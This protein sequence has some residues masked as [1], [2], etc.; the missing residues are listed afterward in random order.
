[1]G[2]NISQWRYNWPIINEEGEVDYDTFLP[3]G[4]DLY[5]DCLKG[6][7]L[8]RVGIKAPS[9]TQVEINGNIFIV[10]HSGTLTINKKGYL[11]T[12]L[13]FLHPYNLTKDTNEI[14]KFLKDGT[15]KMDKAI[16]DLLDIINPTVIKIQKDNINLNQND[17]Q[18]SF[19]D[20]NGVYQTQ[21]LSH[22]N[23]Y[24]SAYSKFYSA[25]AEGYEKFLQGYRGV[26]KID[27]ES[28]ELYNILIDVEY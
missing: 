5:T 19:N 4:A 21:V 6:L 3:E 25:F 1:M 23:K 8:K 11:I 9:G 13:K 16:T 7:K 27:E 18:F 24:F 10:N 26:Y 2:T 12:S 15:E 28:L 17:V 22:P 14:E 20:Q